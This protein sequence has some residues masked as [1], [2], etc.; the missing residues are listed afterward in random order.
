MSESL[1]IGK[2]AE[3]MPS[4]Y[5]KYIKGTIVSGFINMN[6]SIYI[7]LMTEE[8]KLEKISIEKIKIL[9]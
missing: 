6:G 5:K 4:S 9:E 8:M 7:I 3:G 1:I 2:K